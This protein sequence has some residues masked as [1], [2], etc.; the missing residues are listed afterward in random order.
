MKAS[1]LIH[2]IATLFQITQLKTIM[3]VFTL[4]LP[5]VTQ[6]QTTQLTATTSTAFKLDIQATM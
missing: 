1:V 5:I 6:L 4:I 2:Q 3:M